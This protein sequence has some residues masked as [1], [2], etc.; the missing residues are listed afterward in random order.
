MAQRWHDMS[1]H[2]A[3][4]G[5]E[6]LGGDFVQLLIRE[7]LVKPQ[8]LGTADWKTW[9]GGFN[10]LLRLDS[11]LGELDPLIRQMRQGSKLKSTSG[12]TKRWIYRVWRGDGIELGFGFGAAPWDT[13]PH[14]DPV[15]FAFVGREGASE[16]EAMRAVGVEK[17]TRDRWTTIEQL[18]AGCGLTYSW[19]SLSRW[20]HELLVGDTFESQLREA[21]AFVF[22][23]ATYFARRGYLPQ[24]LELTRPA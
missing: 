18:N 6:S 24:Q 10:V 20:A 22:D 21:S 5:E 7:G 14:E 13:R 15:A 11:F 8:P 3:E 19:P 12:L 17:G 23:T 16:E 2:L 1:D 9:N 4:P